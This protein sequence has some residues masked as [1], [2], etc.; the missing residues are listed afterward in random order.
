MKLKISLCALVLSLFVSGCLMPKQVEFGQD[1]VRAFPVAKAKE[2][3]V[4][5]QTAQRAARKA[6]ETFHA[7]IQTQAAAEVVKPA[8]ETAVLTDAVTTSLGPPLAPAPDT[9]SSV[10]LA[11]KLDAAVARLETRIDSFRAANDQNIG[12]AV[13]GTGSFQIG[14]FTQFAIIGALLFFGWIAIKVM[15]IFNPT[16]AVGSRV[17]SGGA[18]AVSKVVS[19]GFS[20]VIEGGE[21]FK[22]Q[23]VAKFDTL[24]TPEDIKELFRTTQQTKQSRDVQDLIRNL[25]P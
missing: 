20:E 11:Q 17:L 7:A 3:E 21:E 10:Q 4:Q 5:R 19:K 16:I 25:T 14:Y 9:I 2:T 1:K 15:G 12:K 24:K 13:E 23:L 6:E 8:A 22:K 18:H